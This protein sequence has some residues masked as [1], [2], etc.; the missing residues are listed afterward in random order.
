MGAVHSLIAH[1]AARAP[2]SDGAVVGALLDARNASSERTFYLHFA[3]L[4]FRLA[5]RLLGGQEVDDVVQDVFVAVFRQLHALRERDGARAW[6][7]GITLNIVR[8]RIRRRTMRRRLGFR[9][10]ALEPESLVGA[11]DD[12]AAA[13]ELR[14]LYGTLE[15]LPADARIALVLK[16]V[17]GMT[18]DEIVD[19]MGRS[20]STVKRRIAEGE[21]ALEAALNAQEGS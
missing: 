10:D 7:R 6:I 13:A 14:E 12:P 2:Q 21:A 19:A 5:H 11:L 3:P 8:K 16:R 20:R 1:R 9:G 15:S 4:V 18:I 17:E